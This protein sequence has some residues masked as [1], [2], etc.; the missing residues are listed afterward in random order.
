MKITTSNWFSVLNYS[1]TSF[2]YWITFDQLQLFSSVF[3]TVITKLGFWLG[4]T[5][6]DRRW[7]GLEC[8]HQ[9]WLRT[10]ETTETT[11]SSTGPEKRNLHLN[12]LI[13]QTNL[14]FQASP[15]FHRLY[16]PVSSWAVYL[17]FKTR[18]SVHFC[19]VIV[20][21]YSS[22]ILSRPIAGKLL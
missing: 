20:V 19:W 12:K 4:I 6:F 17:G 8:E 13:F 16:K 15:S 1:I 9:H 11:C 5:V 21:Y 14:Q 18:S 10:Q 2:Q 7:K 22:K 3:F